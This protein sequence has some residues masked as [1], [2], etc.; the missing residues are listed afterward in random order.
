MLRLI[1]ICAKYKYY[2]VFVLRAS[3]SYLNGD[4]VCA[5]YKKLDLFV[6][7]AISKA[8]SYLQV[9]AFVLF[10]NTVL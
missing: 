7:R 10:Y 6:F 5:K 9:I 1:T 2:D 4:F 3:F 8:P